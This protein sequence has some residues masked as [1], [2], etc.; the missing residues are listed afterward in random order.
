MSKQERIRQIEMMC[1]HLE[2]QLSNERDPS[3]AQQYLAQ[4]EQCRAVLKQ[5]VGQLSPLHMRR[6]AP[7]QFSTGGAAVAEQARKQG[8]E[9]K[10]LGTRGHSP[11]ND[12]LSLLNDQVEDSPE[13]FMLAAGPLFGAGDGVSTRTKMGI[14]QAEE[15]VAPPSPTQQV[16]PSYKIQNR[17][18]MYDDKMFRHPSDGRPMS[19][20]EF[21]KAPEHVRRGISPKYDVLLRQ[22]GIEF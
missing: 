13:A 20:E 15:G 6:E 22:R 16:V 17:Q 1:Q 10:T 8:T 7:Q 5:L 12:I 14:K 18:Q 4:L 9:T 19:V 11:L 2:I 3:V 21:L